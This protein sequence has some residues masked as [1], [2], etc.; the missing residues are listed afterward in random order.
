[1]SEGQKFEVLPKSHDPQSMEFILEKGEIES[2]K[3]LEGYWG[4]RLIEIKD[5]GDA[6]FRPDEETDFLFEEL[7]ME[8]RR[9]DLEL[10]A[11]K[12]DQILG[13]NL[14]PAVVNRTVGNLKGSLQ[15]RIK[16]CY[17]GKDKEWD[18][19]IKP[20]EL[21]RAAIFDYLLDVKDRHSG[22]FIIDADTNKLWLIDHDFFMFFMEDEFVDESR[23][24]MVEKAQDK[25]M[26]TLGETEIS[27]LERFINHGEKITAGAKPEIAEIV[28]GALERAKILLEQKRI[29]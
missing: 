19:K 5:D 6:F 22:N 17:T 18:I 27:S 25:G 4:M 28:K 15:G 1:M 7:N 21:T 23:M 14:V 3:E 24:L 13:F 2:A 12:V 16:N 11:Y 29:V 26:A 20:E 9:S 8:V 10:M